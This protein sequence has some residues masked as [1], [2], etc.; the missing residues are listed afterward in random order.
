[1]F[2]GI[3][4][5]RTFLIELHEPSSLCGIITHRRLRTLRTIKQQH[6]TIPKMPIFLKPNNAKLIYNVSPTVEV[7]V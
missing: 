7:L 6:M 4:L 1:M 2:R 3:T 5:H